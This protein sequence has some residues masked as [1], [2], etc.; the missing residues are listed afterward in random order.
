MWRVALTGIASLAVAAGHAVAEPTEWAVAP[1]QSRIAFEYTADGKAVEGR[2]TE[3]SGR[4]VLDPAAPGDAMLELRIETGSIELPDAKATAFA[5]SAEW[6][7]S[8]TYPE[9]VYRLIELAHLEGERYRAEGDLTIRGKT[10]PVTTTITLGI[11]KET[12]RAAGDLTINRKDYGLG[13][14]PLS[15][16]VDIGPMVTV[17]FELTAHPAT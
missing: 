3:F 6:F 15:L 11:G 2:F 4:G 5:T 10:R 1:E 8:A 13:V 7:D 16:F 17:R 12:A 9:I 14:G